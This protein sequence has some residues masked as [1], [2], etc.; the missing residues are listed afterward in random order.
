MKSKT[1]SDFLWEDY[2]GNISYAYCIV[3]LPFVVWF[4]GEIHE[5][6]FA[7]QDDFPFYIRPFDFEKLDKQ[8]YSRT[9][10]NVGTII[11]VICYTFN[12][13]KYLKS[14]RDSNDLK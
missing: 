5:R 9:M 14:V 7:T 10:F 6:E 1:L 11:F 2:W 3:I 13:C 8:A 12:Q 4:Y